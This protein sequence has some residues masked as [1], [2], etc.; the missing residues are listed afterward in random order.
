MAEQ[1][2]YVPGISEIFAFNKLSL[3]RTLRNVPTVRDLFWQ[4][5]S[6]F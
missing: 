5:F 2:K 4:N 1:F 3:F 6:S